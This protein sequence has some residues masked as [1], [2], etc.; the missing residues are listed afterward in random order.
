MKP[1]GQYY[2]TKPQPIIQDKRIT[3]TEADYLCLIAQLEKAKGCIASNQ[4]FADYFNVKR[5]TAVGVI[6][7]LRKKDFI[8]THEEKS[9]GKT[10]ERTIKIT[11]VHSRELLLSNSRKLQGGVVGNPNSDSRKSH[12]HTIDK[13]KNVQQSEFFYLLRSNGQWELSKDKIEDLKKA[14]LDKDVEAELL[15]AKQWLIDNPAKR[16][17]AKGMSRFLSGWLN[18]AKAESIIGKPFT[19]EIEDKLF[20]KWDNENLKTPEELEEI[21]TKAGI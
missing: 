1:E 14:Y 2:I 18:R 6:S 13:Q 17:T 5:P 16:K 7:S 12:K 15:K 21:F 11:D 10:I 19:P 9:G 8:T 20:Q 4:W 3:S